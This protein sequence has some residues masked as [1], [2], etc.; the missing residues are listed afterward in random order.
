MIFSDKPHLNQT[1]LYMAEIALS[2][3]AVYENLQNHVEKNVCILWQC[4]TL[5]TC[6]QHI[7]CITH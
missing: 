6:K 1:D 5:G 4:N 2:A 3:L 7:I